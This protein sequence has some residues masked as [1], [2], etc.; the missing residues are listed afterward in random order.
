MPTDH[1]ITVPVTETREVVEVP[2][3]TS[4]IET[5]TDHNSVSVPVE[6]IAGFDIAHA[7]ARLK[8]TGGKNGRHYQRGLARGREFAAKYA[9]LAELEAIEA[10][11]C[12]VECLFAL[13][14]DGSLKLTENEFR[15]FVDGA[16]ERIFDAMKPHL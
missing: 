14:D 10:A 2:Y 7:A 9:E 1:T 13:E 11:D 12:D 15:G 4:R 3:Y 6:E 16:L 5:P 8:S